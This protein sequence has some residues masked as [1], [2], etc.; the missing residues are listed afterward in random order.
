MASIFTKIVQGEIPCHKIAE[1]ADFLAFL[2]IRPLAAGHTLVIPKEEI[3][4]VFDLEDAQLSALMVFAKK[5]AKAIEAEVT[6]KRIGLSVIGLEVP[7][8]HV[9]LV[10]INQISDM[11]FGREPVKMSNEEMAALASRIAARL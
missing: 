7:H 10:P 4:Y 5:V 6:C 9:H 8:T 3:D 1:T 11:T 2:D